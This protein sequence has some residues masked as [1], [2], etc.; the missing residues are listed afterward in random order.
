ME[1]ITRGWE[2]LLDRHQARRR[3]GV[4]TVSVLSGPVVAARAGWM[5]WLGAR[6]RA[7][8][9][10]AQADAPVLARAWAASVVRH[11]DVLGDVMRLFGGR[12]AGLVGLA[13]ASAAERE[14]LA[15]TM[16]ERGMRAETVALARQLAGQGAGELVTRCEGVLHT[17]SEPGWARLFGELGQLVPDRA[18]PGLLVVARSGRGDSAGREWPRAALVA[19]FDLAERVPALPIAVA[20]GDVPMLATLQGEGRLGAMVRE[21]LIELVSRDVRSGELGEPLNDDAELARYLARSMARLDALGAPGELFESL[22]GA[23]QKRRA[24]LVEPESDELGKLGERARSAAEE[25][26]FEVLQAVPE[27]RGLFVLNER[28]DFSFGSSLI[29]VDLACRS[30]GLVVEIDGYHHFRDA[31]AYRRDRRKDLSTLR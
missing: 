25:L 5:G 1:E 8:V 3:A 14:A 4:P 11:R 6:G 30:L 19:A 28:L 10:R 24:A 18:L 13:G 12:N 7:V 15:E 2:R 29:E 22:A 21:G 23:A 26:L 9:E 16:L 20:A 31:G 27:T 17:E